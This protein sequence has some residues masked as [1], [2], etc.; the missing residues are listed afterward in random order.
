MSLN[1]IQIVCQRDKQSKRQVIIK[2]LYFKVVQYLDTT[3]QYLDIKKH[4]PASQ[5]RGAIVDLST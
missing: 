4:L 1:E 5:M 3:V 2:P